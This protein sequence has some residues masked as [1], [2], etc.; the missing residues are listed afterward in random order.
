MKMFLSF[1]RVMRSSCFNCGGWTGGGTSPLEPPAIRI[2]FDYWRLIMSRGTDHLVL[3]Q[4]PG[5]PGD[6]QE[7]ME[8]VDDNVLPRQL[9]ISE[10]FATL[11]HCVNGFSNK[12]R[13]AGVFG[14]RRTPPPPPQRGVK[15]FS[16]V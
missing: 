12:S 2:R 11:Y 14:G 7:E 9:S 10:K 4:S 13:G 15:D 16:A 1:V 5:T 6:V 8:P 3:R